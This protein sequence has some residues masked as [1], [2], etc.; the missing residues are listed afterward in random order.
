MIVSTNQANIEE[1]TEKVSEI[2]NEIKDL[3]QSDRSKN[4]VKEA[5]DAVFREMSERESKK[6][7]IHAPVNMLII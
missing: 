6:E 4:L 1:V 2:S 3:K 5:E 7:T